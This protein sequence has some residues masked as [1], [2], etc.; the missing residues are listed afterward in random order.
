MV[1]PRV[2]GG[3]LRNPA[4]RRAVPGTGNCDPI[5]SGDMT[6]IGAPDQP[7]SRRRGTLIR[8]S[9][10]VLLIAVAL[11]VAINLAFQTVRVDGFSMNGTLQNQDFL[12]S[13]KVAYHLHDP[14][15]GDII[16]LK[17]PDAADAG[18][19]FIKR[20][21]G[22]PG[23]VLE[24]D[25]SYVDPTA[26]GSAPTS[27]VL[28]KPGGRGSWQRLVE[29]YLPG[30]WTSANG[31]C[32]SG[33]SAGLNSNDDQP[34]PMT[35]PPNEYFV[36]GDNRDAS[37]DSRYIGLVPRQNII[38]EA[39]LRLYPFNHIGTLG[40]G[41]TLLPAGAAGAAI[42]PVSVPLRRRRPRPPLT[43]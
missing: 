19:D 3:A 5:L 26:P 28:I 23:D 11:Y 30:P 18:T 7:R 31:C 38:A 25:P 8:D 12:L 20:I 13:T 42:V 29:T 27:A 35:I 2:P 17:P 34:H 6:Q 10:E 36:L 22:L 24:I 32:Q 1:P 33:A 43:R 37:K 21:I 9:L 16:V 40:P 15:R 41:P 39:W 14:E 4:L